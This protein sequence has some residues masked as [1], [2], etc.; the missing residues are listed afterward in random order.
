MPIITELRK[1][2]LMPNRPDS[3]GF[4]LDLSRSSCLA[5]RRICHYRLSTSYRPA[6]PREIHPVC[7]LMDCHACGHSR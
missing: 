4:A 1:S 6:C 7:H 5:Y 2:F 3:F